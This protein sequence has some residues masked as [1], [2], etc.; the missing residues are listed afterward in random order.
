LNCQGVI[1]DERI[2]I[3]AEGLKGMNNAAVELIRKQDY[4]EAEK[5]FES[6]ES[7]CRIF[8]Y[9]EGIGM[10]R[11]SMANLSVIRGN[12]AEALTH[13]EVAIESYPQCKEKDEACA[14]CRKLALIALDIGMKKEN[15]GDLAG[16][17]ELFERTLP[18]LN[19]KRA[20]P[21]ANEI[22]KIKAHL[23]RA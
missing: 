14:L 21:V 12:I 5:M 20:V 1:T 8:Q 10:I 11:T 22:R 19:E 7:T 6:A 18:H 4:D 2:I 17:L 3:I 15:A 16:A 13:I 23:G 9:N